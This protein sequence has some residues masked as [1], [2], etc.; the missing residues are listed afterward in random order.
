MICRG[1]KNGT[2]EKPYDKISGD[3]HIS[4]C[5]RNDDCCIVGGML[6]GQIFGAESRHFVA[7]FFD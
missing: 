3:Y 6:S 1:V 5:G 4:D 7:E 2:N